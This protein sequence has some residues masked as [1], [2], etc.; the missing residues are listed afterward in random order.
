LSS[1]LGLTP[2]MRVVV[3][4]PLLEK[5]YPIEGEI[6]AVVDTGY[7]GFV[8]LPRDVFDSLSFDE[9]QL[10]KRRLILAN[11]NCPER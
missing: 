7:E 8:A 9:L 11:G 4:N 3:R 2:T 5:R 10:E 6:L 1:L